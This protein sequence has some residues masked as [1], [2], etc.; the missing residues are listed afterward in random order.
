MEAWLTSFVVVFLAEMGDKTQ[1]LAF[2]LTSRFR[3]PW[4]VMAGILTATLFNHGVS[5]WGGSW[6][7]A[8]VSPRLM[9][10]ILA[11]GFI[12]FGFWT[13]IPDRYEE[14]SQTSHWG[15]F[16]TTTIVFFLVEIGD[17]TQL[18]TMA[19]GAR[20]GAPVLITIGTTLGMLGADGLAVFFGEKV[21]ERIPMKWIRILT[22]GLFFL[23][24][25]WTGW[26]ALRS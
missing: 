26:M 4:A 14:K 8:Q 12:A 23:F 10:L 7:S 15:A 11:A 24:G 2:S 5:A 6:L 16:V 22:A 20:F 18:A 13:L 3:R 21:S 9:G 17:K 1:L 19:L 25:L